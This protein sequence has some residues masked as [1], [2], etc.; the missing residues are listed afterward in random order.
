M[1]VACCKRL[2]FLAIQILESLREEGNF[3]NLYQNM[4]KKDKLYLFGNE[5]ILA[6]IPHYSTMES[7]TNK[8]NIT[9]LKQL[10]RTTVK[11]TMKL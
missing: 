7:T 4:L 6:E 3:P 8:I 5:L 9:I 1:P 2:A 10:R 11:Y